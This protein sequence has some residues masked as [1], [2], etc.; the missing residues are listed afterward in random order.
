MRISRAGG[1]NRDTR[2][3]HTKIVLHARA[4]YYSYVSRYALLVCDRLANTAPNSE[5]HPNATLAADD[6]L[7]VALQM[8]EDG[9]ASWK[10]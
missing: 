7:A 2:L 5:V 1:S 10:V 8:A 6:M 3:I 4:H 9:D